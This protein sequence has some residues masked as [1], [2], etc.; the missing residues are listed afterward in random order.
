MPSEKRG[1]SAIAV[2][3]AVSRESTMEKLLLWVGRL[4]GLAGVL[5]VLVAV[6]ARGRGSYIVAGLQVGT[7]L[8]VGDCRNGRRLPCVPGVPGGATAH[9]RRAKALI[10]NATAGLRN[11]QVIPSAGAAGSSS[12]RLCAGTRESNRRVFGL[13]IESLRSAP[14]W[15]HQHLFVAIGHTSHA[16]T[17]SCCATGPTWAAVSDRFGDY[18]CRGSTKPLCAGASMVTFARGAMI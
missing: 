4:A 10:V 2:L 16:P 13:Q 15:W 17:L 18:D 8:Q 3:R 12:E 9:L 6:F 7:L 11:G 14:A 1:G 5:V